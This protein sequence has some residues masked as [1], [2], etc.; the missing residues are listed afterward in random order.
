M[1]SKTSTDYE[2]IEE[3]MCPTCEWGLRVDTNVFKIFDNHDEI[4]AYIESKII[5]HMQ[6]HKNSGDKEE[7]YPIDRDINTYKQTPY[8]YHTDTENSSLITLE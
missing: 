3:Y 8:V 6:E 7:M 5:E 2:N 1:S 4:L